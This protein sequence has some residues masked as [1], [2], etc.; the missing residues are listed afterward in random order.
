MV[1]PALLQEFFRSGN[2]ASPL[3]LPIDATLLSSY[4]AVH[5]VAAPAPARLDG[6]TPR[7][8]LVDVAHL[9]PTVVQINGLAGGTDARAFFGFRENR[10]RICMGKSQVR[11]VA[12]F[13]VF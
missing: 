10:R 1:E 6:A 7:P 13:D 9:V 12:S 2:V 5:L 11:D 4:R 8:C 3:S